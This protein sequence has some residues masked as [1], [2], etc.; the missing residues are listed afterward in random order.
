MKYGSVPHVRYVR[1]GLVKP[2]VD[3]LIILAL[4]APLPD[5]TICVNV[6]LHG[7]GL[8]IS[9]S[10]LIYVSDGCF[11]CVYFLDG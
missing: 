11:M 2:V 6:W 7:F 8:Y 5:T 4:T 10:L 3:L 9:A 1:L